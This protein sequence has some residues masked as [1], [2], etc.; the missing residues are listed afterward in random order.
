LQAK[1]RC[2]ARVQTGPGAHLASYLMDT[3]PVGAIPGVKRPECIAHHV[4]PSSEE[5]RYTSN[6]PYAFTRCLRCFTTA[7]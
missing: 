7:N 6:I 1:T 3:T 2:H 4:P 5:W